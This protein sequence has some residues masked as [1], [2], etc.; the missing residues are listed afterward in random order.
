ML[1]TKNNLRKVHEW[2]QEGVSEDMFK[3]PTMWDVGS[4]YVLRNNVDYRDFIQIWDEEFQKRYVLLGLL[5]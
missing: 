4:W 3:A 1:V 2:M 5:P